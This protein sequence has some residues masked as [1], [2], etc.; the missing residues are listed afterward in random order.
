MKEYPEQLFTLLVLRGRHKD[1]IELI[2]GLP[3]PEAQSRALHRIGQ[4]LAYGRVHR[5]EILPLLL[6]SRDLALQIR[7]PWRQSEALLSIVGA[8]AADKCWD[9]AVKVSYE[10]GYYKDR[11]AGLGKTLDALA[12]AGEN[13][14]F[15]DLLAGASRLAKL[16]GLPWLAEPSYRRME[17]LLANPARGLSVLSCINADSDDSVIAKA[18]ISTAPE[19]VLDLWSGRLS[20]PCPGTW[21]DVY[22]CVAKVIL[23][24]R[25]PLARRVSQDLLF[26]AKNN[27]RGD[28]IQLALLLSEAGLNSEAAATLSA[29]LTN[30]LFASDSLERAEALVLLGEDIADLTKGSTAANRN[31]DVLDAALEVART[32]ESQPQRTAMLQRIADGFVRLGNAARGALVYIEAGGGPLVVYEEVGLHARVE[33][34]VK[35]GDRLAVLALKLSGQYF[36]ETVEARDWSEAVRLIEDVETPPR[37]LGEIDGLIQKRIE[38]RLSGSERERLPKLSKVKDR[39]KESVDLRAE[40]T[41]LLIRG[42]FAAGERRR[43]K[44]FFPRALAYA[45]GVRS[46]ALKVGLLEKVFEAAVETGDEGVVLKASSEMIVISKEESKPYSEH[47]A[48]VERLVKGLI[49]IGQ[50]PFASRLIETELIDGRAQEGSEAQRAAVLRMLARSLWRLGDMGRYLDLLHRHWPAAASQRE[51]LALLPLASTVL[52][53]DSPQRAD[54]IASLVFGEAVRLG[55]PIG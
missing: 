24:Q 16:T 46:A 9:D 30:T 21:F 4:A 37:E 54:I 32:V 15:S 10:I 8:L 28:T 1:A 11:L 19:L 5:D 35:E 18:L 23:E 38:G 51:L 48:V 12:C 29:S 25:S 36:K 40:R 26:L 2:E 49:H 45:T 42:M 34:L 22:A 6:R 14:R 7:D 50:A 27:M 3:G 39:Y 47:A 52:C 17:D 20:S 44:E 55:D 53:H 41:A 31:T 33:E 13:S 43:A